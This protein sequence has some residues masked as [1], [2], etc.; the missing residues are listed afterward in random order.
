M[1]WKIQK[2]PIT[3]E[4]PRVHMVDHSVDL[5][6]VTDLATGVVD[7]YIGSH[8]PQDAAIHIEVDSEKVPSVRLI[9]AQVKTQDYPRQCSIIDNVLSTMGLSS[10]ARENILFRAHQLKKPQRKRSISC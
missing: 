2:A 1:P 8:S 5:H 7:L 6:L 10:V 9:K 4:S 3:G